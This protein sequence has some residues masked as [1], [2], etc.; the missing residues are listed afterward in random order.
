MLLQP[1]DFNCLLRLALYTEVVTTGRLSGVNETLRSDLYQFLRMAQE[2]FLGSSPREQSLRNISWDFRHN[3][4][5]VN[6]FHNSFVIALENALDKFYQCFVTDFRQFIKNTL[7]VGPYW[8]LP[9]F[10]WVGMDWVKFIP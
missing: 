3:S 2:K 8:V 10:A 4:Q 7:P 9:A 1:L 6:S 5:G